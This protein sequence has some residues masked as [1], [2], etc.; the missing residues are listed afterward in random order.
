MAVLITG[1]AGFIGSHLVELLLAKTSHRLVVVDNFDPYY[2]PIVK[3]NIAAHLAALSPRITIANADCLDAAALKKLLEEHA[4]RS[5]VHLAASPGVPASLRDP[6][7]CLRNNIEA[8]LVLLELA[9]QH[10]VEQFLFASS[11]TVY[12]SGAAAPFAEDAPMGNPVSPYGVSK[13]AA[14]QLGFNYH[15]LYQI[16]FVSLRFFNA[17]GIRI[18]P[19]LAL[20]AFTRAILRGEP[21]KLFGDG[22]ALRDFTHVTDI[23]QG[24]LQTLEHP[25]FATAV[26][27][28]AFNLG[29]CAPITVRQLI[30]MIEAAAGR[31]AL[32]EQLPSRTEDMLRTHASLEKSARVLGY[33]PTR[34]IE[35][36]VPRYVAWALQEESAG[37]P[38]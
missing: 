30:D 33:Q 19:E 28:E 5:I 24:L 8:T 12:G 15:H 13:R 22:S 21:L 3:R 27:G 7:Q 16:P 23:A 20:A 32:I 9:R 35:I 18:R 26:A 10:R 4:V 34:Q 29:S 6:R 2:S 36:E 1:G 17:Y 25:H 37:R 14:E 38:W 11:S 31:R